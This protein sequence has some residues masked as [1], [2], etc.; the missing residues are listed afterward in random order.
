MRGHIKPIFNRD[1]P[2]RESV[3]RAQEP[4]CADA[5]CETGRLY[6][7]SAARVRVPSRGA[8]VE[9]L[10]TVIDAEFEWMRAKV[11]RGAQRLVR[12][13]HALAQMGAL[14]PI[15]AMRGDGGRGRRFHH[16]CR[17]RGSAQHM[18]M[19]Y[20]WADGDGEETATS[21]LHDV[22]RKPGVRSSRPQ[23]QARPRKTMR[24]G[25]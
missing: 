19:W 10:A 11:S 9:C 3:A 7:Q 5:P 8:R 14:A 16:R 21:S 20:M 22:A 17:R 4:T 12:S 23:Y 13:S 18:A 25:S 1:G 6:A 2:R 24:A 15:G